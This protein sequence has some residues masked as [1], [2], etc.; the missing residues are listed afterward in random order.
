MESR[1]E[2]R[3]TGQMASL[4]AHLAVPLAHEITLGHQADFPGWRRAA[5]RLLAAEVPPEAVSWRVDEA[6]P[7]LFEPES[8]GHETSP[9]RVP[10]H[11]IRLAEQAALHADPDR[12]A[13]L[14]RLL[15]RVT[16]GERT[17]LRR[18]GDRDVARVEAMAAAVRRAAHK[19][20][21]L[22]RF[23]EVPS[24]HGP[25]LIAWF[26]PE[27]HVL[28]HV[29]PS[30][31]AR[32]AGQVWSI[33]TPLRSAH[34]DGRTIRFGPGVHRRDAP[35]PGAADVAWQSFE[36]RM[37][38][39]R[40]A[41]AE[42]PGH[43]APRGEVVP[44]PSAAPSKR[45]R[46]LLV[47]GRAEALQPEPW[48]R[49]VTQALVDAGLRTDE[50]QWTHALEGSRRRPRP[51]RL[52]LERARLRPD[53][54]LALGPAAAEALLERPVSLALERGRLLPLDDGSRLLVTAE[55]AAILALPD[56]TAQG[57]EYRRLVADLLLAVPY[58]RRAA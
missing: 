36:Q 30:F 11:L 45:T 12:F 31:A 51:R 24:E 6:Q 35:R 23:R 25:R 57:R 42:P 26:E 34:S 49:L 56:A 19:L 27:H 14:Y 52:D 54:V 21:T 40:Q 22:A 9:C 8:V 17:I 44:L 55:P 28:D 5:R 29:A 41:D 43:G 37:R 2:S 13:L 3:P 53:L 20:R 4:P 47:T 33:V 46:M 16:H 18:T 50:L 32:F 48:R 58:Q 10:R 7:S 38:R 39:R 15:W 1:L